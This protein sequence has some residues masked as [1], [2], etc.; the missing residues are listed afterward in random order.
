MSLDPDHIKQIATA[1]H[2][3]DHD[4]SPIG[5]LTEDHPEMTEQDAYAIQLAGIGQRMAAHGSKIVGWKVGLTS[6]AMQQMLKV[7]Q[8]DFGHLMDDMQLQPGE[9]LESSSRAPGYR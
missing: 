5:Q 1:L 9:S 8:P 3:A 4:R 7:D 2:K 6:K